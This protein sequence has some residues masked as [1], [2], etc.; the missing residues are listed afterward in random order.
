MISQLIVPPLRLVEAYKYALYRKSCVAELS[1][2]VV[3]RSS[4]DGVL[5]V[6]PASL[7]VIAIVALTLP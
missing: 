4:L 3:I 2:V 5:G 6:S 7:T 1:V